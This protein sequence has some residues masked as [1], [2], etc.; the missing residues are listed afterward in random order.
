MRARAVVRSLGKR[1]AAMASPTTLLLLLFLILK[2]AEASPLVLSI[3]VG[4]D[5]TAV[6]QLAGGQPNDPVNPK[7][8]KSAADEISNDYAAVHKSLSSID[9]HVKLIS[10]KFPPMPN[11]TDTFE[12]YFNFTGKTLPDKGDGDYDIHHRFTTV[13]LNTG[14]IREVVHIT[15][16]TD[17][18]CNGSYALLHIL[19][20]RPI[21]RQRVIKFSILLSIGVS[22]DKL[23]PDCECRSSLCITD[24]A[25]SISDEFPK[26]AKEMVQQVEKKESNCTTA[27]YR[28]V[29]KEDERKRKELIIYLSAAGALVLVLVVCSCCIC[30]CRRRKKEILVPTVAPDDR[31]DNLTSPINNKDMNESEKLEKPEK[32]DDTEKLEAKPLKAST[33]AREV[34]KKQKKKQKK[35]RK[36]S[37]E[38]VAPELPPISNLPP[39]VSKL[40]KR[41][42]V[43][44]FFS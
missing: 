10:I 44:A 8:Q 17:P 38:Q 19:R 6:R 25:L 33:E 37:V 21:V 30:C 43:S 9:L 42:A 3:Q 26:C 40:N 5:E 18:G 7:M 39:D 14:T 31:S 23:P 15:T 11:E 24:D 41:D 35:K 29:Q 13:V 2:K 36:K 12:S 22:K 27:H 16:R 1:M 20:M 4:I 28:Y 32:P 34:P